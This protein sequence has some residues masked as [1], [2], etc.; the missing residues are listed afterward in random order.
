[1]KEGLTYQENKGKNN[2]KIREMLVEEQSNFCAYTEKYIQ[3]LDSCEVEHFDSS[4]KYKDDYYNY[5]AVLRKPNQYKKDEAYKSASFFDNLFFHDNE[6]FNRRIVYVDGAYEETNLDDA[7]ARELIDFLGF[8][9]E[10]LYKQRKRH[11]RRLKELFD[12][13]GYNEE[14]RLNYFRKNNDELSFI[15]ALE[16]ELQIDLSEFFRKEDL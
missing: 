13:A 4:K 5:Y 6:E 7:E 16:I 1:M 8:N 12:D 15:T 3:E 11:V 9:H 2:L 10:S 14:N